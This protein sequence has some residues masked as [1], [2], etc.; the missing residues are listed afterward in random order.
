MM[1]Q[2]LITWGEKI[3]S[4]PAPFSSPLLGWGQGMPDI[5]SRWMLWQRARL[6]SEAKGKQPCEI[7]TQIKVN[8]TVT[9]PQ[10]LLFP[11]NDPCHTSISTSTNLT[12]ITIDTFYLFYFTKIK[13][14]TM[15]SFVSDFFM[16]LFY[17]MVL[18][19]VC[20][21]SL[22]QYNVFEINSC[23]HE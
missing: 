14:H 4:S 16:F 3:C 19:I 22:M 6:S 7:F 9:T 11:V 23:Y 5:G 17:F 12:S 10:R 15:F 1:K 2:K 18:A 20:L 21:A 8:N 13:S